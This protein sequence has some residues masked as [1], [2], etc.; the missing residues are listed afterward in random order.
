MSAELCYSSTKNVIRVLF[1]A[2]NEHL[3]GFVK[4][5]SPQMNTCRL[6]G[7]F[8][9]PN[10]EI[11]HTSEEKTSGMLERLDVSAWD[12]VSVP[13]KE[14]EEQGWAVSFV[15]QFEHLQ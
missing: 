14:R 7:F 9:H 12:C 4:F 15:R 10:L 6:G 11:S 8:S 2:N 3:G 13:L 5:F 1:Y